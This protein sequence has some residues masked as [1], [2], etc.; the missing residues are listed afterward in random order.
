[1]FIVLQYYYDYITPT[2]IT[3]IV[4][5]IIIHS[6][7]SIILCIPLVAT[8]TIFSIWD[9]IVIFSGEAADKGGGGV[10]LKFPGVTR[11]AAGTTAICD[12]RGPNERTTCAQNKERNARRGCRI[13]RRPTGIYEGIEK[14]GCL[15]FGGGGGLPSLLPTPTYQNGSA[16]WPWRKVICGRRSPPTAQCVNHRSAWFFKCHQFYDTRAKA[17]RSP[18]PRWRRLGTEPVDEVMTWKAGLVLGDWF[19]CVAAGGFH[20]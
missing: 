8:N 1:M 18:R 7:Y 4:C 20:Q 9:W 16:V 15:V 2:T 11:K 19:A 17:H 10:H 14:M 13:R 5:C 6:W 12:G 3:V